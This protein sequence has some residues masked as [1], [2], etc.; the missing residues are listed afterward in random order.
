MRRPISHKTLV[1]SAGI[2][3]AGALAAGLPTAGAVAAN[4]DFQLPVTSSG[5]AGAQI[6]AQ[7]GSI[8]AGSARATKLSAARKAIGAS[9]TPGQGPAQGGAVSASASRTTSF[10]IDCA[11]T[12]TPHPGS[13]AI[14]YPLGIET[15]CI[16]TGATP[17][18]GAA[19][20]V[21][22]LCP[23]TE[24]GGTCGPGNTGWIQQ[25]ITPDGVFKAG[26][27]IQLTVGACTNDQCTITLSQTGT[28]RGSGASLKRQGY[29]AMGKGLAH[30][31]G[32]VRSTVG[33]GVYAPSGQAILPGHNQNSGAYIGNTLANGGGILSCIKDQKTA[34]QN[35]KPVYTCSKSS[36]VYFGGQSCK[37]TST[38]VK[39]KTGTTQWTS[40][41]VSSIAQSKST[42]TTTTP[43]STTACTTTTP[44]EQCTL[45]NRSVTENCLIGYTPAVQG[46]RQ[47]ICGPD[48]KFL[49]SWTDG[50]LH[51]TP[52]PMVAM[53]CRGTHIDLY[54]YQYTYYDTSAPWRGTFGGSPVYLGSM[55][56]YPGASISV[57]LE[58]ARH[59]DCYG[60]RYR[61]K[62][63]TAWVDTT[64]TFHSSGTYLYTDSASDGVGGSGGEPGNFG[65]HGVALC[66][67]G[68]VYQ[69]RGGDWYWN[70]ANN[71]ING[72]GLFWGGH[73]PLTYRETHTLTS[74]T[75]TDGCALYGG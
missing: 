15:A 66:K 52:G 64:Y 53:I 6:G 47:I 22:D 37:S 7:L 35:G 11:S 4:A 58:D 30:P 38:C 57:T 56:L 51:E 71:G 19:R 12:V 59:S 74:T 67:D 5:T 45:A 70:C 61:R 23:A 16:E 48:G 39:W 75:K 24:N 27:R 46:H 49:G 60:H 68:P 63:D 33:I 26:S 25:A 1:A 29:Q 50:P 10:T 42:C 31:S 65:N 36:S 28:F 2:A 3:L 17:S 41:C 14:A 69:W 32:V 8:G 55:Q 18:D 44:V 13:N 40:Q 54:G 20:Y 34:L 72:A 21:L 43:V 62:C 73:I 9:A